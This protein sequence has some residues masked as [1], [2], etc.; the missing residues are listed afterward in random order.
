ME[1]DYFFNKKED[2]MI[3]NKDE[4]N[5]LTNKEQKMLYMIKQKSIDDSWN[6]V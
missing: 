3:E 6:S 5:K 2:K 1:A 4:I